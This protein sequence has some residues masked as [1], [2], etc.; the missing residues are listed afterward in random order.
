M[1]R[2]LVLSLLAFTSCAPATDERAA[3][4]ETG[5]RTIVEATGVPGLAVAVVDREGPI[6]VDGFGYADIEAGRPY[7]AETQHY[8]ASSTKSF[9]GLAVALL[10]RDGRF[11]L[12]APLSRYL[13]E[14]DLQPGLD[15]DSIT[16]RQLLTHTH[17][18]RNGGPIVFRTAFSGEHTP[19]ILLA[20][21]EAAP[22]AESGTTFEYGNTGYNVA[23]MAMDRELG[24]SW[25]DVLGRLVFEPLGMKSTTAYLS[26]SDSVR[27]EAPYRVEP[28][29]SPRR[30]AYRKFDGNMHAAGGVVTTATDMARWLEVQ[31]TRGS[32]DDREVFPGEVMDET[33]R[34]QA[35]QS[36]DRGPWQYTG[37]GL[38]WNLGTYKGEPLMQHN[39]GY[40]G[41]ATHVSLLPERGY[42]VAV[43]VNEVMVGS[44]VV[45]VVAEY[46]YDHLLGD[47]T[48]VAAWDARLADLPGLVE[49]ARSAVRQDRER[50]AARS[51]DLPFPRDAYAGVF[52]SPL[53]GRLEVTFDPSS[54]FAMRIGQLVDRNIEVYSAENNQLRTEI[55][56]SGSVVG[57]D[58]V[59]GRAERVRFQGA[60]LER[61]DG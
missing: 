26:R 57:F 47:S 27:L 39:G 50:R 28:D 54:G 53:I 46:V 6:L 1:R 37:Y 9:T 25:K 59:D 52:E 14:L 30:I 58:F 23:S 31:L 56:G 33:H 44:R 38:G 24:E 2:L 12:D 43:F 49:Q 20:A 13:P 16:V 35:E 22:P 5:I 7:T 17:G 11:E 55:T 8:I 29:G 40:A 21:L 48:A 36:S 19:E 4:L 10:D 51:Q 60:I 15:A 42:G 18:I 34:P 3:R 61:V 45:D 32:V 41:F